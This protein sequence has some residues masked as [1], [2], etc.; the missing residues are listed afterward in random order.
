M[1][2]F[3]SHNF[4]ILLLFSSNKNCSPFN[5][6][7]CKRIRLLSDEPFQVKNKL[8]FD[9]K[10]V[11]KANLP[12]QLGQLHFYLP[13][14]LMQSLVRKPVIENSIP[15]AYFESID[16]H[17]RI[18]IAFYWYQQS[19]GKVILQEMGQF[20]DKSTAG[21]YTTCRL[22]IHCFHDDDESWFWI[23]SVFKGC[24]AQR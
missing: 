10:G 18:R 11:W 2:T 6:N 22:C 20:P 17:F 7:L 21:L 13:M 16:L 1:V 3:H 5:D 8:I 4:V 24:C 9:P 19:M 12:I 23:L 14:P 15:E